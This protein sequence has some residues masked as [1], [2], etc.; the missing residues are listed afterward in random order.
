METSAKGHSL[1]IN[2]LTDFGFKKIFGDE[3]VMR[4]FLNDLLE[5]ASEIL[6]VEP[7]G[8][9]MPA[10]VKEGRGVAY[11]VRCRTESG[12]EFIVEMQNTPQTHVADRILFYLSRAFSSQRSQGRDVRLVDGKCVRAKW[13]YKLRP[14]YCVFFMNFHLGGYAPR[15]RRTVKLKVEETGEVFTETTR[16]YLLELP[17]Y[18]G[19]PPEKCATKADEWLY[20]IA[21]MSTMNTREI[22]F[23]DRQPAMKRMF[24][25]AEVANMTPAEAESYDIS[26]E[27][28][29]SSRDSYDT[30]QREG[31]EKGMEK[32]KSEAL[33]GVVAYMLR[34]GVG[35]DEIEKTTGI[36]REVIEEVKRKNIC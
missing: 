24:D 31:M 33:A 25:I 17:D 15:T 3:E 8:G 34:R 32:G 36:A 23:G 35:T 6:S 14:V 9:E 11:D 2:P 16:A 5:P 20:N 22:P 13:D 27:S 1:Y 30:A 21:N 28:W 26:F 19:M 4:A 12:M 18:V 10:E 29:L 7:I